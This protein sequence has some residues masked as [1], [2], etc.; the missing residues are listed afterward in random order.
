M[1]HSACKV[2]NI[3]CTLDT[4][5]PSVLFRVSWMILQ[6]IIKAQRAHYVMP[7]KTQLHAKLYINTRHTCGFQ[8]LVE[9][10]AYGGY[11]LSPPG[12]NR[13]KVAA[14]TLG[15]PVLMSSCPHAHRH[16]CI[17]F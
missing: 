17:F 4:M 12:L 11:N 2:I 7:N 15:G 8:N 3:P 10:S 9:T 16:T 1:K 5:M 14:K 6:R 13:V